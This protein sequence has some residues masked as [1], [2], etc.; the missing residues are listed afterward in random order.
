MTRTPATAEPEDGTYLYAI[1]RQLDPSELRGVRGVDGERPRLVERSGLSAVVGSVDLA[2]FRKPPD[3][4]L[5]DVEDLRSLEAVLRAHHRVVQAVAGAAAVVPLRL[6]TVYRDDGRV[7]EVLDERRADF[8]KALS[9]VTGR[10]EWGVKVS[11]T[12]EAFAG[13]PAPAATPPAPAGTGSDR[14]GTEYL[15]RRRE[16]ERSRQEGWDR[17]AAFAQGVHAALSR[18]AVESRRHTPQDPRLSGQAGW[19]L[20]NGAYLVDDGREDGLVAVVDRFD[21]P[22]RGVRLE[23]TG[24]WAPYSFTE[25]EGEEAGRP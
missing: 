4:D 8:E 1:T 11:A 14:P 10:T 24:P 3:R 2:R 19:M 21:D 5:D 23:L 7:R 20:L 25:A 22:D 6:G 13:D 9:R 16:D 17:A 18:V 12:P 15:R